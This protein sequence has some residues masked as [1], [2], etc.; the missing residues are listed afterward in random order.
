MTCML[1]SLNRARHTQYIKITQKVPFFLQFS[2]DFACLYARFA[3]NVLKWV[4]SKRVI[5]KH[6]VIAI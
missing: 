1:A 2:D 6:C 4:T 3:R 5:F